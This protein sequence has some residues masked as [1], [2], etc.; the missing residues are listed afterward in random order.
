MQ[1][2]ILSRTPNEKGGSSFD[3]TPLIFVSYVATA[4]AY[5]THSVIRT[6]EER[7][8]TMVKW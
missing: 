4:T 1:V 6:W 5:R 3:D 7:N 2:R 8:A